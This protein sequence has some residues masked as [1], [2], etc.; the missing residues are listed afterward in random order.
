[1][2]GSIASGFRLTVVVILRAHFG[3]VG[4]DRKWAYCWVAWIS[5]IG[6]WKPIKDELWMGFP[7]LTGCDL[8]VVWYGLVG[9]APWACFN[10]QLLGS[11]IRLW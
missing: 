4:F 11:V 2:T 5:V 3:L 9:L 10:L 6:L 7:R 1:M 8:E